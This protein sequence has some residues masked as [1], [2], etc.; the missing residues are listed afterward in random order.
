MERLKIEL[1]VAF[2]GYKAHGRT[3]YRL[4][5]SLGITVVILVALEKGLDIF[6]WHQT[7]IMSERGQLTP[8]V[9]GSSAGLHADEAARNV[10]QTFWQ[11][12]ARQSFAQNDCSFGVHGANMKGIFA[13]IDADR[14]YNI[15]VDS[16]HDCILRMI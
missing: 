1:L 8:N 15:L 14:R 11:C 16:D 10:C 12:G 13:E 6:R 3:L 7:N 2:E 4:G 9:V 5:D